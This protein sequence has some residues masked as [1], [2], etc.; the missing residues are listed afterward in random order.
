MY[1]SLCK[2]Y[3]IIFKKDSVYGNVNCIIIQEVNRKYNLC[4]FSCYKVLLMF[5][6]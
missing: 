2:N 3:L 5:N 6:N 1:Y 4:L